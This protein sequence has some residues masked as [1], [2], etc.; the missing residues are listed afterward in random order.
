M[1]GI[2]KRSHHYPSNQ[3]SVSLW[4]KSCSGHQQHK[5]QNGRVTYC[6]NCYERKFVAAFLHK[7]QAETEEEIRSRQ[8]SLFD[9]SG[10][11]H[12]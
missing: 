3:M 5:I 10:G 1:S 6:I 11:L 9:G 8:G 12:K 2:Q 7:L 4:C